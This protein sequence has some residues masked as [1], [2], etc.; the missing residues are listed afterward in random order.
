MMLTV[1]V[2]VILISGTSILIS[3]YVTGQKMEEDVATKF[4]NAERVANTCFDLFGRELLFSAKGMADELLLHQMRA[5]EKKGPSPAMFR[6]K[7]ATAQSFSSIIRID[8]GHNA[9]LHRGNVFY[10]IAAGSVVLPSLSRKFF[11]FSCYLL[12]SSFFLRFP[13][14]SHMDISIVHDNEVVATTLAPEDLRETDRYTSSALLPGA[15]ERIHESS[16]FK[17]KMYV[18]IKYLPGMENSTNSFLVFSHPAR[19]ILATKTEFG[20]HFIIIFLVG[21]CCSIMLIFFITGSVLNPIKELKQLVYTISQ[22]DLNNRIELRVSNEFTPLINQFNNMLNLI[23]RKDEELWDIV[24]AKTAELRQRNVFIDNLLKSSQV[25]GI[26]ATDMNLVVTYFNPVAEKLFGFKAEEVVGKK[27]TEF[28]PHI[29]NQ[30]EQ[31]N[32]L[33]EHTLQK[34]SH[35]FTIGTADFPAAS[36][37]TEEETKKRAGEQKKHR[38]IEVYLSPIK[39]RSEQGREMT[40]G[41]MLMAQD[42]TAA[43]KMD[44]RL[45]SALAE[46]KVILD[47]T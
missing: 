41:L 13:V 18:K 43:R 31:F 7:M 44:E 39:A 45:H 4:L 27:V 46:L 28:H 33:I 2:L 15:I 6:E 24:A 40:S 22:G 8:V 25:M 30:E 32:S 38:I 11:V 12:D 34:G 16:F 3:Y 37:K 10:M 26:V 35:T 23:Q 14:Y 21:I 29:K 5:T 20:Q 17:E 19:L 1:L 9:E 42:I 36:E 47:N